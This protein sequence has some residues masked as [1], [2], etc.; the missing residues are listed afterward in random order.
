[1]KISFAYRSS[2]I[3]DIPAPYVKLVI[4]DPFE[5]RKSEAEALVDT[6][7][8]GEILIPFKIYED[9]N[10]QAFEFGQ[11]TLSIAETASGERLTLS[12]ASGAAKI[13]GANFSLIVTIDSHLRCQE[14]LIG[15][16]FLEAFNTLM[17]GQEKQV[18]LELL[19]Q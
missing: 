16:K 11:D 4:S 13:L 17:K 5:E 8:D 2:A 15:R 7:F 1:M 3:S 18:E 6:G 10:L 9:L 12:S 19:T 14:V